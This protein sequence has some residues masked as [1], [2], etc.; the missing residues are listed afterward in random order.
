MTNKPNLLASNAFY[1]YADV[2]GAWAFYRDVLGFETVADYGFAKI[3]RLAS[4]S[5]LTLVDAESG[6]H[7]VDEPKTVTLALVSDQVEEWY[8]YL[9][10]AGVPMHKPF[11]PREGSAHDGFVALDPEGY[12]LEFERFNP[13]PE[14]ETLLPL[15]SDLEPI[16]PQAGSRP[17]NLGVRATVL[18]LYYRDL[19]AMQRFYERLLGVQLLVDQGWAK[20][21]PVA[22]SG[23]IGLVDGEKGLHQ[24]TEQKGVMVSFF[25][26]DVDA[27]F[28]RAA[29]CPGFEL[30]TPE[31]THE[32]GRVRLFV[33]YDPEGYYL[34]WDTFIDGLVV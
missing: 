29:A 19:E 34:E 11:D 27:W 8:E 28:E 18:W 4:S 14:N 3:L 25:T 22:G 16:Y 33:G 15:L 13:H 30:R 24:A 32:S 7:S 26:D 12:Y 2:E 31:V 6:L 23:F 10:A 5:Y 9:S 1:Y 20:V 17:K 21:Y